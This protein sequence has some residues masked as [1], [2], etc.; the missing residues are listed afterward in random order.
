MSGTE[1]G[2]PVR[3]I[4]VNQIVAY[5]LARFRREAHLTQQQA[6][7]RAGWSASS[8]SEAERSWDSGR[9]REFDAHTLT[10]LAITVGVPVTGLLL[11][12]D[13]DEDEARYMVRM[14]D[15]Q[16]LTM[17]D[18]VERAVMPDTDEDTSATDL[19]RSRFNAVVNRYLDPEWAAEAA[20]WLRDTRSPQQRRELAARLRDKTIALRDMA[21]EVDAL[22][23]AIAQDTDDEA[24][25]R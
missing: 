5:N 13:G 3:E 22:W 1:T 20:G 4:T 16:L 2:P 14:P 7:L 23:K 12:P 24:A 19:Y 17:G 8:V 9:T 10:A 21:D 18:Y 25:G 11:P 6:G 15:R